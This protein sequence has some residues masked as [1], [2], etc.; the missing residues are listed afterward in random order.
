MQII[1]FIMVSKIIAY[2]ILAVF[3][4]SLPHKMIGSE[5]L[6]CSQIVYLSNCFYKIPSFEFSTVNNFH[7]VT[8]YWSLFYSSADKKLLTPFTSRVEI[9][10]EFMDSNLL[11]STEF[12]AILI[13]CAVL[14]TIQ[15]W[16][17]SRT[18]NILIS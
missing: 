12:I 16:K 9:S 2:I 15:Y 3:L 13:V 7:L 1:N 4:V 6:V 8:G 10:P 11:V 18:D 5:L 14:K 17:L